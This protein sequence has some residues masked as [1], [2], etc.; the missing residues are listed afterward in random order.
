ML[1]PLITFN[2]SKLRPL[3]IVLISPEENC[4]LCGEQLSLRK[5]RPSAVVVYD[6][7]L[8]SVPGSHYH[9]CC[10][11]RAACTLTQYYGYYTVLGDDGSSHI[12]YNSSWKQLAYFVSSRETAFTLSILHRL[13]SEVLIGQLSYMYKQRADIFNHVHRCDA[14]TTSS[15]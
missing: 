5:D 6:D 12:L 2:S 7:N 15:E 1:K 9:K 4:I 11:S 10:S 3:G 13:D 8:G 14:L